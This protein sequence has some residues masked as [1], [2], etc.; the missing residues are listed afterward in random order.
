VLGRCGHWP[1]LERSAESQRALRD[2][3][4]SVR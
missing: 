1:M 3:L 4:H 2:F